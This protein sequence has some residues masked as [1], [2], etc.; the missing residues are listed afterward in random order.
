MKASKGEEKIIE[1]LLKDGYE[2]EREKRFSDLRY[3]R[4]RF[5]FYVHGGRPTP[6]IIEF[7]GQQHYEYVSKFYK[8][9][10]DFQAAKERDRRK[11]SYCLAKN[12]P[13]YCI[14][15]WEISNINSAKELFQ[16]KFRA[17]DMWKNDTDD[18][19]FKAKQKFDNWIG[20]VI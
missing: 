2:F 5:D 7:Q 19:R 6:C 3:G 20:Y 17:R 1:L 11:L 13:V 12:I 8:N 15:Y 4:F 18:A 9:Q 16:D 14:P 10:R